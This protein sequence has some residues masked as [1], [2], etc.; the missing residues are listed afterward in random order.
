MELLPGIHL[1]DGVSSNAYLI[2]E[3]DGLT[4]IDTGMPGNGPKVIAYVRKLGRDPQEIQRILLTHQHFDH[5]GGAAAL[6]TATGAAMVAHPLD[7]PAIEG[8]AKRQLP[9][10]A[11][12]PA[13]LVMAPLMLKPVQ[14]SQQVRDGETL[15][16]LAVEG[17]LQVIETPGHTTGHISFYLPGRRLLFA[18]DAWMHRSG[19]ILVSPAI[20]NADNAQAH[21]TVAELAKRLDI[22]ASL[23]G[24]GTPI[25]TGAGAK[26]AE[27]AHKL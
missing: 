17:G 10:G 26:L 15:P 3:P 27:T 23:P 18:G 19:R 13:F 24:H 5:V 1:I 11:L 25:L 14:V 8:K 22:E 4:V 7:V 20:F 21:R 9:H 12:H 16:I 6:A 2:V